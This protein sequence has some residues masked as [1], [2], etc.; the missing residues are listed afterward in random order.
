MFVA[1]P[2][3][4]SAAWGRIIFH[5]R[6][7]ECVRALVGPAVQWHGTILHAKPP[8]R[9]TPFPMHQDY[10]FYPHDGPDFVDCLLHLDDSPEASGCL[11]VVPG[12]HK[13]GPLEHITGDHT[14]PYL[15]PE[16]YHPDKTP[17]VPVP[18]MA[19]DVI[20]FSYLTIHWSDMNRT[21]GWRR[22][23]RIG[24]HDA[25]MRPTFVKPTDPYNNFVVSGLKRRGKQPGLDL[26]GGG[27]RPGAASQTAGAHLARQRTCP[28]VLRRR[29]YRTVARRVPT[30]SS[31]WPTTWA[32]AT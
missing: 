18:A 2:Q 12:S 7:T 28:V 19:G 9:G 31:S 29:G 22:S 27:P 17:S 3:F 25:A 16:Q 30:S 21:H 15:P 4:Y 23:V 8:E 24:F 6:L 11:Q 1:N 32:T 14:R 10:P 13:E 26:Q 5:Q 20:F